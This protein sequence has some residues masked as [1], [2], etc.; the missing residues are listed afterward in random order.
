MAWKAVIDKIE[1]IGEVEIGTWPTKEEAKKNMYFELGLHY[2]RY[3]V[4]EDTV[5]V[6]LKLKE[7]V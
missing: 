6:E 3:L 7:V 5:R 4:P 2:K 1:P